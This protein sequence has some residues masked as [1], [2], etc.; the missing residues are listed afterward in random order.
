MGRSPLTDPFLRDL[1]RNGD[2]LGNERWSETRE[3][4]SS[5][6]IHSEVVLGSKPGNASDWQLLVIAD[7]ANMVT[8]RIRDSIAN[9]SAEIGPRKGKLVLSLAQL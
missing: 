3:I 5:P 1:T 9:S 2:E 8:V 4:E 7:F 6:T